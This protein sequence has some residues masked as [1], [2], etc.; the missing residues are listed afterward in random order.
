MNPTTVIVGGVTTT[1]GASV[2][3]A[4]AGQETL[5]TSA[6]PSEGDNTL[7]TM[8]VD[9]ETDPS[10][11]TTDRQVFVLLCCVVGVAIAGCVIA[12]LVMKKKKNQ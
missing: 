7:H 8:P 4:S 9:G 1:S 2:P 10:V 11:D 12:V 3:S 6:K 5:P